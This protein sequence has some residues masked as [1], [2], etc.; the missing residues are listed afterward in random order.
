MIYTY[1]SID[2]SRYIN[3]IILLVRVT[4]GT[5]IPRNLE[6]RG[7]CSVCWSALN[8]SITV[9]GIN[10]SGGLIPVLMNKQQL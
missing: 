2:S 9:F 1:I 8:S 4:E 7:V 5:C 6:V 3:T 10:S